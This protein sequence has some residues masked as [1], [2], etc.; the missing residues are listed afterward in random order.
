MK[1]FVLAFLSVIAGLSA[2]SAIDIKGDFKI[3]TRY[4]LNSGDIF[5]NQVNGSLKFENAVND[6]LYGAAKVSLRYIGNPYGQTSFSNTLAVGELGILSSVQPLEIGLDEAYF[7]YYDFLLP[8]LDLTAGKQRINWGTADRLNPTDVLNAN[9]FSDP[10][11]FGKKIPALAVNLTAHFPVLESGIQMVYEPYAPIARLNRTMESGIRDGL[12]GN[13]VTNLSEGVS[14]FSDNSGGW[15]FENAET[16]GWNVSNFTIGVKAFLTVIGFDLSLSYATRLNDMPYMKSIVMAQD[17]DFT[18]VP[19]TNVT[20]LAKAYTLG[21]YREHLIG[22]D[23]SKDFDFV[24][25]WGEMSVVLPGEQKTSTLATNTLYLVFP[26]PTYVTNTM[27]TNTEDVAI[28][29]EAYVKYTI[30]MGKAFE[31][32]WYF[33]L[34]YNHGFFN[35]RGNEGPERLQDYLLFRLEKSFFADKLKFG[36]TAMGNINTLYDCFASSDFGK[37]LSE[38]YGVMGQFSVAYIPTPGLS[39]EIGILGI[40]GTGSAT[41]AS[42]KESDAVYVKMEYSF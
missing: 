37:T 31:G 23:F 39:V 32:G 17:I 30:G 34:Q 6:N 42:M 3:D 7:T 35:E 16:P 25:L 29:N 33:N 5:F 12:Y 40:D 27:V 36:V 4:S 26:G 14:A 15:L 41:F 24:L 21:Y 1:R 38:N 9:D 13:L 19:D 22:F 10:F 18:S 8:G 2:V 11:D 20:L 28:S